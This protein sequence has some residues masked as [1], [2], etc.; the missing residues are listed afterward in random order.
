[1]T[2]ENV[3]KNSETSDGAT[4]DS[5]PHDSAPHHSALQA[6]QAPSLKINGSLATITLQRPI[7]RNRLDPDDL[8]VL[9]EL[10][11]TAEQNKQVRLLVVT[12]AG[13]QSFCSGYT[14]QSIVERLDAAFEQTLA[15]LE[16]CALPTVALCNGSVYGGGMDL[17]LCCDFRIGIAGTHGFMPAA[18]FGLHYHPDGLR[19]FTQALGAGGAKRVLLT[20]QTLEAS[21]LF[22]LG[23]YTELVTDLASAKARVQ[24][25]LN[26]LEL[27]EPNVVKSMK[28]QINQIASGDLAAMQ[29]RSMYLATLASPELK[30]RLNKLTK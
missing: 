29:D 6:D 23:F 3:T 25:T 24:E 10:I 11:A 28:C 8:P 20:A 9:Q 4:H 12:G 13:S 16:N 2:K 30:A 27:C 1:V 15:A 19:R 26:A 5:A 22:E 17:A 21:E 18:K 7:Q 14:V